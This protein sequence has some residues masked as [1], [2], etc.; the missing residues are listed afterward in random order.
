M[1]QA[2]LLSQL[3]SDSLQVFTE[4]RMVR[5][6][7]REPEIE[8]TYLTINGTPAAY[9]WL[10]TL[11]NQMASSAEENGNGNSVIVSPIDL[12]Q[13]SMHEWSALDLGCCR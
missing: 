13:I 4:S 2:E 3:P 8:Q 9:R 6:D 10:A 7:G 1:S 12:K 11:L 5:V